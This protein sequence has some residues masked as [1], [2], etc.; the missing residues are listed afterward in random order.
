V[1][2]LVSLRDRAGKSST[3]LTT[4][5]ASQDQIAVQHPQRHRR[6]AL[7]HYHQSQIRSAQSRTA[8]RPTIQ[9]WP[10]ACR[11]TAAAPTEAA[12]HRHTRAWVVV[13]AP[14]MVAWAVWGACTAAVWVW[15]WEWAACT[16][17]WACLVTQ[18]TQRVSRSPSARA[19]QQLSSSLKISWAHSEGLRRCCRAHIWRRIRHSSVCWLVL[20]SPYYC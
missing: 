10:T 9:G 14:C 7:P 6:R 12:T 13:M 8:T 1:P 3:W 11:P 4:A 18:T 15:A 16:E 2:R 20:H 19:L 5:Q 17:A